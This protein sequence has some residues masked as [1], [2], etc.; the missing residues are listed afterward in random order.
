[1]R[2]T[3][4]VRSLLPHKSGIRAKVGFKGEQLAIR[5]LEQ[6]GYFVWKTNWTCRRGELDI[7][8]YRGHEL[9]F[10]EVKSASFFELNSFDP[11]D[12]LDELKQ[13][14]LRRL[15]ERFVQNHAV[16]IKAR[17]LWSIRID[18]IRVIC[19]RRRSAPCIEHLEDYVAFEE[20][21]AIKSG[22]LSAN[23]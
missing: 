7:V 3:K 9:I 18:A 1:M 14:K 12:H 17:R 22:S 13:H 20:Q 23:F 4:L 21:N 6:K 11:L 15:A 16:E 8:A 10:A 5:H 2:K 19:G